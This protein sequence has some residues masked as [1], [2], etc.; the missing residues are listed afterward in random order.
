MPRTPPSRLRKAVM[1]ADLK[2]LW[3]VSGKVAASQHLAGASRT[4]GTPGTLEAFGEHK[5]Q[6]GDLARTP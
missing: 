2:A 4:Q 3:A 5:T 1:G 6:E